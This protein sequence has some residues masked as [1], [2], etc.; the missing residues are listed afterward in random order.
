MKSKIIARISGGLGNQMFLYASAY[1]ISKK[2]N[3]TLEL[4]IFSSYIKSNKKKFKNKYHVPSYKLNIF[5]ITGK[6]T[7]KKNLFNTFFL[8]LK[9]KYLKAI[10]FFYKKKN[11]IIEHKN[12]KKE[13]R[14]K[15][16]VFNHE[17]NDT[18]FLE[19]YFESSKYFQEYR[20]DLIKEFSIKKKIICVKEYEL[21]ILNSNAVSIA[22]RTSRYNETI[23][24]IN[25]SDENKSYIFEK[26]QITY[27][28]N[29]I[30]YFNKN[31]KNP[32]YFIFSDNSEKIKKLFN[33]HDRYVFIEKFVNDKILEDYYLMT[34]CKHFAVAPTTFHFWPAWLSEYNS[35]I[36]LKPKN[37]NASNNLD[38]WPDE[39]TE[40]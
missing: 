25:N 32:K 23:N 4:D 22:V 14:Y 12:K 19:G 26:K 9:R 27:I 34:L 17:L 33:D 1:S 40:I 18:V 16:D 21:N 39:W 6:I 13:T 38:Y 35:K 37:I 2:L 7:D 11:F 29:C 36:C 3:R 20:Y 15:T 10:D 8:N 5:N 31:L 30:D 28:M 24:Q